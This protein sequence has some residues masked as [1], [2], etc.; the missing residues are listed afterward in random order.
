LRRGQCKEAWS[1]TETSNMDWH[2]FN[3]N[4][5]KLIQHN[6]LSKVKKILGHNK[7]NF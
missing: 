6:V 4:A 3:M 7:T 1:D 2:G 5:S